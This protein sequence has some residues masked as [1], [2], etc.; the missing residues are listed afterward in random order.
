MSS[1][2]EATEA[3]DA[4]CVSGGLSA[5][6]VANERG[7]A[8]GTR[9]PGVPLYG[10]WDLRPLQ[11]SRVLRVVAKVG[12]V[13]ECPTCR[14]NNINHMFP[15]VKQLE[16][17]MQGEHA[18][19]KIEWVCERCSKAYIKLHAWRCH[20]VKCKG[21]EPSERLAVFKCEHCDADFET[22]IRLSQHERHVHPN[23]RN[24]KRAAESSVI[25]ARGGKKLS[26]W[27]QEELDLLE[28]LNREFRDERNINI[29]L[30]EYFPG[31]TNKQISDARRRFKLETQIAY[32]RGDEAVEVAHT[33]ATPVCQQPEDPENEA[34]LAPVDEIEDEEGW[35]DKLKEEILRQYDEL[36]SW[37]Q[38]T[39]RW[40]DSYLQ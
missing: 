8:S 7:D 14:G 38:W 2:G 30:M 31:R 20:F 33:E 1:K 16:R 36:E 15:D 39:S 10:R 13:I 4:V 26:V 24:E 12:A 34:R 9:V 21:K 23:V 27:T 32:E 19:I 17:Y 5:A 40:P 22:K 29:K 18:D 6:C 37:P 3:D 28:R 25:P 11:T 35:T